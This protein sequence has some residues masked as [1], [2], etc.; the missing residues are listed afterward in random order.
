M[1]T[2]VV[3]REVRVLIEVRVHVIQLAESL[4]LNW[5]IRT[6]GDILDAEPTERAPRRSA[7]LT[8]IHA[9]QTMAGVDCTLPS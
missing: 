1:C 3:A 8:A 6:L 9:L 5:P 4:V 2:L 7:Q